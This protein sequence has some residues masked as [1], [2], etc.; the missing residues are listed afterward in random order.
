MERLADV[1]K[2]RR[3][4][5]RQRRGHH[6]VTAELK[7]GSTV[8]TSSDTIYLS[9]ADPELGNLP[10]ALTFLYSIP[11]AKLAPTTV[12]LTPADIGAHKPLTWTADSGW[13][14]V[15]RPAGSGTRRNRFRSRLADL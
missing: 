6:T 5:H 13:H 8:V 11:Q 9:Q 1:S 14:M 10:E 3:V 2:Q 12:A 15:Q 7:T 4:D